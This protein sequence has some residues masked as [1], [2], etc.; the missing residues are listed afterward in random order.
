MIVHADI[1]DDFLEKFVAAMGAVK[2][3][4]PLSPEDRP[5][6]PLK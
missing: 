6:T 5:G 3:G 4:D 2:V 1:Y